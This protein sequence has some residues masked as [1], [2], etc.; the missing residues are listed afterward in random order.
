MIRREATHQQLAYACFVELL[1]RMAVMCVDMHVVYNSCTAAE[2]AQLAGLDQQRHCHRMPVQLPVCLTSCE[3]LHE[4]LTGTLLHL[5]C[6][7]IQA[8]LQPLQH[9]THATQLNHC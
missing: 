6:L 4:C 5:P 3:A 8:P 7:I 2:M 9:H 1:K